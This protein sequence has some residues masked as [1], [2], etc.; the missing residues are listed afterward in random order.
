MKEHFKIILKYIGTFVLY[1]V[2]AILFGALYFFT[3][4]GLMLWAYE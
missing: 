2:L 4:L 3:I 1:I